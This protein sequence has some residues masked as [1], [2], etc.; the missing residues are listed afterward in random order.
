MLLAP[1]AGAAQGEPAAVDTVS[2]E[3]TAQ[4]TYRQDEDEEAGEPL[5]FG[6]D[7]D[8]NDFFRNLN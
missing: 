1:P 7:D 6:E 4:A 3:D 5:S 2:L 8:T